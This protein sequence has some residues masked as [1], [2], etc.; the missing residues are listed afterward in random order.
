MEDLKRHI[1]EAGGP[2]LDHVHLPA[3]AGG[4]FEKLTSPLGLTGAH[5]KRFSEDGRGLG[6][7]GRIDEQDAVHDISHVLRPGVALGGTHLSSA[8]ADRT[9]ELHGGSMS[10]SRAVALMRGSSGGGGGGGGGLGSSGG[11]RAGSRFTGSAAELSARLPGT[12]SYEAAT[13][14]AS[15]RAARGGSGGTPG[16]ELP[17]LVD[18]DS[19]ELE[20][21]FRAYCAFGSTA[22][23][24]QEMDS[25][26]FAK[27]CRENGIMD[28]VLVTPAH[29][30]LA[31][32]K[33]I[34]RARAAQKAAAAARPKAGARVVPTRTLSYR[35]F[36]QALAIL[37]P[38]RFPDKVEQAVADGSEIV[39]ALQAAVESIIHTGGPAFNNVQIP[40]VAAESV[41][42]KLTDPTQ[43]PRAAGGM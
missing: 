22:S 23:L 19:A 29:V 42:A 31:F 21:I 33:A 17:R 11:D 25:A 43:Y 36:Q 28:G 27:L 26:R 6:R 14:G 20:K 15:R 30:D 10:P 35:D 37:A 4:V 32:T 39:P 12:P 24:A 8:H 38:M 34:E 41:F 3:T 13:G 2:V 40:E 1:L 7:E 5:R 9:R 18:I 16:S